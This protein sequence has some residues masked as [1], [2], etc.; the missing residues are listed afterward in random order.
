MARR[1]NGTT[2]YGER[3]V[4]A[5]TITGPFTMAGWVKTSNNSVAN[6]QTILGLG[7]T[8]TN[9]RGVALYLGNDGGG[10]E[11]LGFQTVG[12]LGTSN[13]FSP[14]GAGTIANDTWYHCVGVQE[15]ALS[16][17]VYLNAQ[18]GAADVTDDGVV[19]APALLA[20]GAWHVSTGP[21]NFMIGDL[22]EV[23]VWNVVLTQAE[24]TLLAAGV[25]PLMIRPTA[26]VSYAPL[27]GGV[28]PEPDGFSYGGYTLTAAPTQS[29]HPPGIL[30]M[31]RP[32]VPKE[33]YMAVPPV[34]LARYAIPVSTQW[35]L[36]RIDLRRRDE[37]KR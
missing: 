25:S 13:A 35:L 36:H 8:A 5:L 2:Q 12:S 17:K 26:L 14:A 20:A 29:V 33:P 30:Y 31:G 23:A 7:N 19:T 27:L 11:R 16:R 32:R 28:S 1:F 4:P 15:S 18:I 3:A 10:N 34:P 24:V 9:T 37:G 21:K 6:S 22:A